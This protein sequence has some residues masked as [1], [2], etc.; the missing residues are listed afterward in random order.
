MLDFLFDTCSLI[1]VSY[2]PPIASLF[3]TRYDGRAGWVRVA[4]EELAG[5]RMKLP[6]NPQAGRAMSW[7]SSW[8]G[9]PVEV[10]GEDRLNLV[11][12]IRKALAAGSEQRSQFAHL[13][14][15]TAIV[16]LLDQRGGRLLS[17]DLG[18]RGEARRRRVQAISSVGVLSELIIRGVEP[19]VLT[20]AVVDGYLDTLRKNRRMNARL[21]YADLAR[22]DLGPWA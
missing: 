8:L 6:P 2:C 5:E 13:G 12:E 7:A 14:E 17:D 19:S 11:D 10:L 20:E 18:A 1:N 21:T 15:A 9:M 22:G 4:R 16:A 3:R